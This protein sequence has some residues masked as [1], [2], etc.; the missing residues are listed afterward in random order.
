M[1]I[2]KTAEV[3][4]NLQKDLKLFKNYI[5]LERGLSKNTTESYMS[6]LK[7]FVEFM[8]FAL[9]KTELKNI[10]QDDVIRYV[11]ELS[12]NSN[13]VINS[14]ARHLTSLREFF[15]YMVKR[16]KIMEN[17]VSEIDMPKLEQT[18]PDVLAI[19]EIID[20]IEQPDI[21]TLAGIRDRTILEL[22][23]A[24]GLRCSEL[25]EMRVNQVITSAEIVKVRGKGN[26]DRIVPIGQSALNWVI[27][28]KIRVRPSFEKPVISEDYLFLS[29]RGAKL[30][31]MSVWKMVKAYALKAGIDKNVH[32]HTFRHS[33]ATHLLEGGADIRAVQEM[34]GHADISTTQ[35]YTHIDRDFLK[36]VHRSFH[37]RA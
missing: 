24:C 31:R 34:L 7:Q 26:V 36:E 35:I 33:F 5:A 19:E 15:K 13:L 12:D 20:I 6:D 16:G 28:Y 17:P 14:R 30:S 21:S 2:K 8:L 1:G 10:T 25:T 37:P 29:Q 27:R 11:S 4:I 23:Y 9:K 3:P 32:P 18:L 22:L